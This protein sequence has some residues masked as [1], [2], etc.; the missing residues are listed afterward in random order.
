MPN[1]LLL[2]V[3][4]FIFGTVV[5]SFLNVCI[6]RLPR[7]ESIAFPPS[8]CPTCGNKIRF[9]HN[10][11]ILGYLI[12]GG[13]CA[14]CGEGISAL[15]PVVE[16]LS[17]ILLVLTVYIHGLGIETL[18]YTIFVF[19][20]LVIAFIDLEHM[21]IPNVISLPGILVGLLFNALITDW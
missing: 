1:D 9:Y 15:Y 8:H 17:G 11:P 18:F 19:S 6:Y 16:I 10:I 21:I 7:E 3:F 2:Y 14:D 12:L 4:T 13:K 5:G 20:L